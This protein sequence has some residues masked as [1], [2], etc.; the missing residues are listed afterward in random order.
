MKTPQI[1]V[2]PSS[3]PKDAFIAGSL[4]RYLNQA[5]TATDPPTAIENHGLMLPP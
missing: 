3:V 4:L 1:A 2:I 5:V